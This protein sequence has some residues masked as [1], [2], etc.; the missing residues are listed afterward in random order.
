MACYNRTSADNNLRNK[1]ANA[2]DLRLCFVAAESRSRCVI[3][4]MYRV[5]QKVA[6]KVFRRFLSDRLEF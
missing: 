2:D 4:Y 5:R 3:V 1:D 6:P